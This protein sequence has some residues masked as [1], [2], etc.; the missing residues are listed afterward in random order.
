MYNNYYKAYEERYK[1]VHKE[2]M[3]WA[4]ILNT[5]DIIKFI[6]DCKITKDDRILDLGC[7]EG[8]DAIYLLDKGYNVLAIDYSK[9]AINMCNKLSNNKYIKSFRSLDIMEDTLDEKFKY[10]YSVAVL[11][12]FVLSEHRNKYFSFIRNHLEYDGR[13]LLCVIGNGKQNYQSDIKKA[14]KNTERTIMNNNTKINVTTTFCKI[15]DWNTLEQEILDNGLIIEN[16]WISNDVP[17]FNKSMCVVIKKNV[18]S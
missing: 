16:K 5:P 6:N 3:L 4:F 12:M 8:R 10:I 2:N 1:Q 14:F 15:V 9:S 17:E 7:G 11:H 13:C 18:Y